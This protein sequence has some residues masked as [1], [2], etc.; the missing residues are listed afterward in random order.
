MAEMY[1]N[2]KF[3]WYIS[4]HGRDTTT[5]GF[6]KQTAAILEFCFRFR[7]RPMCSHRHVILLL[8]AKFRRNQTIH[9]GVMTSY[10][11]FMV[12]AIE[13]EIYFRDQV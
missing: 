1:L 12:A 2:T 4:I 3:R 8:P 6:G 13:S 9:G 10:R 5:S 11:F 7:F